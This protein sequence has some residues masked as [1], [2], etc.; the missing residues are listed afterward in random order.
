MLDICT[1]IISCILVLFLFVIQYLTCVLMI[2]ILETLVTRIILFTQYYW[3][4]HV[5]LTCDLVFLWSCDYITRQLLVQDISCSLHSCHNMYTRS[6]C[7]WSIILVIPVIVITFCS[8]YCQLYCSYYFNALLILL[9]HSYILSS[10][11]LFLS[12]ILAGLILTDLYY[13]SVSRFRKLV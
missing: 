7:T 5:L 1:C 9:L 13:F 10:T 3:T 12:C 4:D 11:V 8:R 2:L 6:Y